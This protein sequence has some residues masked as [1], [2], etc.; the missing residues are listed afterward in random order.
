MNCDTGHLRMVTDGDTISDREVLMAMD[1]L[2][3]KQKNEMKVSLND[4]K[5]KAGKKRVQYV[6]SNPLTKNQKRNMRNKLKRSK[7]QKN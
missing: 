2:T 1:E 7:W 5:S 3:K 6:K 4:N